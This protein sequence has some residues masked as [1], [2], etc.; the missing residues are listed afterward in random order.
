MSEAI[1]VVDDEPAA[2]ESIASF[3]KSRGYTPH[4]AHNAINA[5]VVAKQRSPAVVLLDIR[6][7]GMDG[8][9]CLKQLRANHPD[10]KVIMT[11]AMDETELAVNCL[12][13]GAFGYM[14]KPISLPG[15]ETE[16]KKAL[17]QRDMERQLADYK[18]NLEQKVE[19]RTKEAQELNARLKESFFSSIRML[20]GIIEGYDPF[21]G[22]HMKRASVLSCEMGRV[23][24]LSARDIADVGVAG[25]LHDVGV[26]TLPRE[27]RNADFSELTPDQI[28]FIRQHPAFAQSTLSP[29]KELERAGI[30]IRS[31]LEHMDG[32]GFPDGL[33]DDKI[34]IGSRI[35]GVANA[36]DEIVHRRRF[37]GE[38]LDTLKQTE[39]FAFRQIQNNAGK[40]YQREV[41]AALEPAVEVLRLKTKHETKVGYEDLKAGMT[42]ADDIYTKDGI[43]LL[44]QGHVLNRIQLKQ[45]KKFLEMGLVDGA[46]YIAKE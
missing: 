30:I 25:F 3:L 36:F 38:K 2:A 22:G 13:M 11:T 12:Q 17:N 27:W 6:M 24:K 10:I 42:L 41:V 35:L 33:T 8:F 40:F 28:A 1:L 29:S 45:I 19:E 43:L 26:I 14:V 21:V 18:A 20:V 39:E 16:I 4:T 32:T 44:A 15:L 31:H 46:F 7:P 34:P 23:L 37:T 5:L 9:S